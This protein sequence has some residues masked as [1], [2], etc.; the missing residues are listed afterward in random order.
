M[1]RTETGGG[2]GKMVCAL[3]LSILPA[4]TQIWGRKEENGEEHKVSE[5]TENKQ[6]ECALQS[7]LLEEVDNATMQYETHA[8]ETPQVSQ[9]HKICI[10]SFSFC[11]WDPI[12]QLA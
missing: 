6:T 5:W 11:V 7:P 4:R 10:F 2:K 8:K 12:R 1:E 3:S 9:T